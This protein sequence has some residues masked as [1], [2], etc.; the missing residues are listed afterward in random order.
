MPATTLTVSETPKW[1]GDG[2]RRVDDSTCMLEIAI[3]FQAGTLP[4]FSAAPPF[5][6]ID[7]SLPVVKARH[8]RVQMAR[9]GR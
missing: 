5:D 9:R 8:V 2:T 3:L 4:G 1:S 6:D 7:R